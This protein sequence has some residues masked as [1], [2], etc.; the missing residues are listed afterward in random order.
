ME[1]RADQRVLEGDFAVGEL[2]GTE[3]TVCTV[4]TETAD[5]DF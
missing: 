1:S 3:V 2:R 5:T 4:K